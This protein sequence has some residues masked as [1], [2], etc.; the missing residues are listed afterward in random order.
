MRGLRRLANKPCKPALYQT[1]PT[2]VVGGHELGFA[3]SDCTS[4]SYVAADGT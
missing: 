1:G 2:L 3:T 4:I